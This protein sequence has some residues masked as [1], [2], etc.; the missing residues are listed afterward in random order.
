MKP[1]VLL[2]QPPFIRFFNSKYKLA[3]LGALYISA[4][5]NES[6]I[7]TKVYDADFDLSENYLYKKVTESDVLKEME[8]VIRS[9]SPNVLG[10]GALSNQYKLALKIARMVKEID[11]D[12]IVIAGNRHA[13]VRPK[14]ILSSPD[15]D[16]VVIGEGEITT[17]ELVKALNNGMKLKNVNGIAYRKNNQVIITKP[18]ELIKNLDTLPFPDRKSLLY[19]KRYPPNAFGTVISSR[20]CPFNCAFC[21]SRIFWQKRVRFRSAENLVDELESIVKEFGSREFIFQDDSF[22]INHARIERFCELLKERDIDIFWSCNSRV[23]TINDRL[24]KVMKGAGFYSIRVG[25]ESGN[26]SMLR[27]MKKGTTVEE[28]K[29][30]VNVLKRNKIETLGWFILGYP[31]ENKK[32]IRD[33]YRLMKELK[34]DNIALSLPEPFIGTELYETVKEERGLVDNKIS[35][36]KI[37]TMNINNL[38]KEDLIKYYLKIEKEFNSLNRNTFLKRLL[39]P[40]YMYLRILENVKNN[41]SVNLRLLLEL[42]R[43]LQKKPL[44]SNRLLMELFQQLRNKPLHQDKEIFHDT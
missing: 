5:L 23:D 27:R 41:P 31:G 35:G 16:F 44:E 6:N 29:K 33:T 1:E 43:H 17:L 2:V 26:N 18:R 30:A 12:I 25:I 13:S 21:E 28:I 15:F 9:V 42:L 39:R 14:E 24:I 32:T 7:K 40:R 34:L 4:V 38:S 11:S 8:R 20:G 37:L 10:I 36:S 3:P 19:V 22:T